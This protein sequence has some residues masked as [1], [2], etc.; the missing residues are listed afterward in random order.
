MKLK[1]SSFNEEAQI[2]NKNLTLNQLGLDE[3]GL[4]DPVHVSVKASKTKS[5][6]TV[7][8]TIVVPATYTCDR[9]LKKFD[10]QLKAKT[11]FVIT[12][13][14]RMKQGDEI[15]FVPASVDEVDITKNIRDAILLKI[16]IKKICS[17]DCKGLCSHCGKNLNDG[18]CDCNDESIDPRWEKLKKLK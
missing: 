14:K 2:V 3:E 1:I 13:D 6:L 9:C 4:T 18:P 11:N 7:E 10:S 8:C 16:P 15:V 5:C 17:K 12:S